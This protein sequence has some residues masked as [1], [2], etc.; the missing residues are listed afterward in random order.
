MLPTNGGP[1]HLKTTKSILE[2]Y[3]A[4]DEKCALWIFPYHCIQFKNAIKA[5]GLDFDR[6]STG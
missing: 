4:S 5:P 6:D 2:Q 1:I 3:Y